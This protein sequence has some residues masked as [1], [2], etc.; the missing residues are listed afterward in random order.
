MNRPAVS[1]ASSGRIE[2]A[3]IEVGRWKLVRAA[4]AVGRAARGVVI[5]H[6]QLVHSARRLSPPAGRSR[7]PYVWGTMHGVAAPLGTAGG[8]IKT[9]AGAVL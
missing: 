4:R 3:E 6:S 8:D 9:D 7:A 5:P 1:R 2:P